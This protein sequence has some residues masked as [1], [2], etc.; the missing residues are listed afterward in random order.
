MKFYN[1]KLGVSETND[2]IAKKKQKIVLDALKYLFMSQTQCVDD[3]RGKDCNCIGDSCACQ[4]PDCYSC[5]GSNCQK[6]ECDPSTPKN[7]CKCEG[8]KC[9]CKGKNCG[10]TGN[11]CACQ[12]RNNCKCTDPNNGCMCTKGIDCE[13]DII[14]KDPD[15]DC[16]RLADQ[17]KYLKCIK[18][19]INNCIQNLPNWPDCKNW[20][21]KCEKDTLRW[22]GCKDTNNNEE[23]EEKEDSDDIIV[24]PEKIKKYRLQD[25]EVSLEQF[26]MREFKIE[27]D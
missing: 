8:V 17:V 25:N 2:K 21:G 20:P 16:T 24:D 9:K 18:P 7:E 1:N 26:E 23:K 19:I 10:C 4:G 3:C 6:Y 22:P 27:K 15:A 14:N 11:M 12:N 5:E 13:G